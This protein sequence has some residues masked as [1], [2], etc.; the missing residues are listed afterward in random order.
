[1]ST[2]RR[3]A[4]TITVLAACTPPG[5]T[6]PQPQPPGLACTKEAKMC[7]DGSAVGRTGPECAFPACPGE[8]NGLDGMGPDPA[9]PSSPNGDP[10]PVPM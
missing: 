7:S 1:M 2:P 3:L 6:Q 10:E 4:L 8:S 9:P 5:L